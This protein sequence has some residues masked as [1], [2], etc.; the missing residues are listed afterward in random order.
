MEGFLILV[1]ARTSQRAATEE[2]LQD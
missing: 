1:K 2:T